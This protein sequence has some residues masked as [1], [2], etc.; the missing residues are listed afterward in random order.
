MPPVARGT[1]AQAQPVLNTP[2][3][4]ITTKDCS[5]LKDQL[6]WL[7]AAAK[8][9]AHFAQECTDPDV[10]NAIHRIGQ[11]HQRQYQRLLSHLQVNNSAALAQ[12]PP[13]PQ[14]PQ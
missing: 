14:G 9:C 2:P 1:Q 6:S 10:A 12:L 4:V 8:K 11:M 3:R 5:Y 7:L 13:M